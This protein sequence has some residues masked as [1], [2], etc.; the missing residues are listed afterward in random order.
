MQRNSSEWALFVVR[1]GGIVITA[2]VD[3]IT[4]LQ[5]WKVVTVSDIFSNPQFYLPILY[6]SNGNSYALVGIG[7]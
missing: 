1:L 3:G 6:I 4:V 7:Q 5:L 2:V